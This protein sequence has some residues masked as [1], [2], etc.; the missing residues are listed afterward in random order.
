MLR[1]DFITATNALSSDAKFAAD[2]RVAR[3]ERLSVERDGWWFETFHHPSYGP[4]IAL[5][6]RP[7]QIQ[8]L[9][10]NVPWTEPAPRL[11]VAH[12]DW[13]WLE[14]QLSRFAIDFG[15]S[16]AITR[17]VIALLMTGDVRQAA[18]AAGILRN[19]ARVPREGIKASSEP[20]T[21]NG[22]SL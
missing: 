13:Q 7:E 18:A 2:W 8:S 9:L 11:A 22:S 5:V 10:K 6:G 19:R 20:T 4:T 1:L 3:A 15:F 16:A 12:I 21:Y 17:T 14:G